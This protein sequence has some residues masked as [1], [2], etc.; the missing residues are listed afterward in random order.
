[1]LRS[2]VGSEMCIRDRNYTDAYY[3]LG[4]V[5]N[6]P[7]EFDLARRNYETAAEISPDNADV[8]YGLGKL[9]AG[10]QKITKDGTLICEPDHKNAAKHYG[11]AIE[12]DPNHSKA[13]FHYALLLQ[14]IGDS[15]N[16]RKHY[17]RAIK[18][19]PSYA[20]AHYHLALLLNEEIAAVEMDKAS[21]ALT[22][23]GGSATS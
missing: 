13:H 1:M 19:D 3:N 16:A 22:R 6:A 5:L 14:D 4:R 2:L 10:G 9:L 20:R 12:I 23:A 8:H 7:G 17:E 15:K 18:I 11:R 21:K